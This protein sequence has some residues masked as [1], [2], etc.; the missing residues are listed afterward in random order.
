MSELRFPLASVVFGGNEQAY[1]QDCLD[2]AW[3]SACGPY[4]GR[5]ERAFADFCGVRHAVACANGTAALHLALLGLGIGPGDEVII[6]TLTYVATANAVRYC[7]AV[8]V[9]ADSEPR[10]WN[11]DPQQVAAKITPRTRAIIVVHLYGQPANMTEI[12]RLARKHN[13]F[14]VE[15]AAQAHG[16]RYDG[17]SVGALG[18]VAAFSFYGNKIIT[19]GE[20]GMVV[21]NNAALAARIA[22]LRGQG[23]DTEHRYWFPVIGYNYRMTNVQAALGLAQLEQ[24]EANL[25]RRRQIADAY[26]QRLAGAVQWPQ[27]VP[28]AE[29]VNWLFTVLLPAEIA[30]RRDEA[31]TFLAQ[32]GIETRPVFYPMHVLPPHREFARGAGFP[33]ADCLAQGGLSLPTWVGLKETDIDDICTALKRWL[34]VAQ[35]APLAFRPSRPHYET[36]C[37]NVCSGVL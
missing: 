20:G 22:Q 35:V 4:V 29:A 2:T 19:T 8:P 6:P 15:D 18:D 13:L 31:M 27:S 21:T 30:S 10:T 32:E 23:M 24:V 5:F 36:E 25:S 3:I 26:R 34:A 17:Q 33:V 37:A 9:L 1:V 12:S 14:V 16:A 7:G 28:R 11:L